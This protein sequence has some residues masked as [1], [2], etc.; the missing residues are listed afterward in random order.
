M[1][2]GGGND[3]LLLFDRGVEGWRFWNVGFGRWSIEEW[4]VGVG[5]VVCFLFFFCCVGVLFCSG[6]L[7][8]GLFAF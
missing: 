7:F 6:C 1:W 3:G 2:L 5:K 8:T 4:L